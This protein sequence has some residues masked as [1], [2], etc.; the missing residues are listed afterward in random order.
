LRRPG[1][2][3]RIAAIGIAQ[4]IKRLIP[5]PVRGLAADVAGVYDVRRELV[6]LRAHIAR[7]EQHLYESQDAA[8]DRSKTRWRNTAPTL[9]LTWDI[10]LTGDAFIEKV[11]SY[12]AF[13]PDKSVLEIGPGYGRLPKAMLEHAV[14]MKRYLGLDISAQNVEMLR[15]TFKDPRMTF[16]Q[17][18]II[19]AAPPASGFDVVISSLVFKHLFPSF[20]APLAHVASTLNPGAMVFI[21]LIEGTKR[22]FEQDDVTYIRHY[23]RDEVAGIIKRAGLTLVAFDEV[24]HTPEFPRLLFVARK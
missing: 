21:D 11:A 16:M 8:Q 6:E 3:A 1:G 12:G 20:E 19:L 5:I 17:G 15:S 24:V 9:N 13:G 7:V 18:D 10:P 14:P 2:R 22:Y 4:F 23:S